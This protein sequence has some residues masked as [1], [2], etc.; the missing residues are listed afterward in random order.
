MC[1][2]EM[3][4]KH[5]GDLSGRFTELKEMRILVRTN[6][7]YKRSRC[8]ELES[9]WMARVLAPKTVTKEQVLG[10]PPSLGSVFRE[11]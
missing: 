3:P 10:T 1:P 2:L 6:H 8:L 4:G 11:S 7:L 9:A 5:P